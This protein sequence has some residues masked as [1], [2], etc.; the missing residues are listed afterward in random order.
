MTLPG[1]LNFWLPK[2]QLG[3]PWDGVG[4]VC[5]GSNDSLINSQ[6]A[7]QIWLQSDGHVERGGT[8]TQRDTAA[9]VDAA[10]RIVSR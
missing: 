5:L 7:C 4:Q 1:L 8:D 3:P 6:Y 2:F 9:L 10:Q